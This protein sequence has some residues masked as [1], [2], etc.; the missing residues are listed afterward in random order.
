MRVVST[1]PA[2]CKIAKCADAGR[3]YSSSSLDCGRSSRWESFT[4]IYAPFNGAICVFEQ[5]AAQSSITALRFSKKS[6]WKSSGEAHCL[7]ASADHF[8][9]FP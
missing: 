2:R 9:A 8:A 5:N 6:E 7:R 3:R 4:R 1:K